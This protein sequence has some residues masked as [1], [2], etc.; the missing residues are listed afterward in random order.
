MDRFELDSELK[1]DGNPTKPTNKLSHDAVS[2]NF[3]DNIPDYE[4]NKLDVSF[5]TKVYLLTWKNYKSQVIRRWKAWFF[6][7]LFPPVIML[8]IGLL[9]TLSNVSNINCADPP[10]CPD[11]SERPPFTNGLYS[12]TSESIKPQNWLDK[13]LCLPPFDLSPARNPTT[14]QPPMGIAV[15]NNVGGADAQAKIDE[16]MNI[17]NNS[18]PLTPTN[19]TELTYDNCNAVIPYSNYVNW[20]SDSILQYFNSEDELDSYIKDDNYG[21]GGFVWQGDGQNGAKRPIGAAI[22]F[23]GISDD[24]LQWDYTLRLNSS[25]LPSTSNIID[26]FTRDGGTLI[27]QSMFLYSKF[28]YG[29][30]RTPFTSSFMFLQSLVKIICIYMCVINKYI[31]VFNIRFY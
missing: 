21:A 13:V 24:N 18:Y 25:V 5:L 15:V 10:N 1:T 11:F 29:P 19:D 7:M 6:K 30:T 8:L 20:T 3:D 12:I 16:L 26:E 27:Q 9:S 2:I 4:F 23:N 22:I 14:P 31:N 17:L 28:A